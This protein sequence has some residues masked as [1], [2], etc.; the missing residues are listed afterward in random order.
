MKINLEEYNNYEL[1]KPSKKPTAGGY[2]CVIKKVKDFER[3]GVQKK[4]LEL[5]I[6]EGE[7][8]GYFQKMFDARGENAKY[9]DDGAQISFAADDSSY[10]MGLGKRVESYN[11]YEMAKNIKN[12]EWDL[13]TL[14]GKKIGVSFGLKEYRGNDG[15]VYTKI[16][17]S[18]FAS[19]KD[20][21]DFDAKGNVALV[22]GGGFIKYDEY[23][24]NKN[25]SD[26]ANQASLDATAPNPF[27]NSDEMLF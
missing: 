22:D 6:A 10:G 12:G 2:V 25:I 27:D 14:E 1:N 8:E 23:M 24:A 17:A 5:D 11:N 20:D 9:W 21:F 7:F 3:N 19:A 26:D 16:L 18:K 13:S 4:S 15:N